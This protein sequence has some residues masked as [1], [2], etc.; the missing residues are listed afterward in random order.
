MQVS[1]PITVP[2]DAGHVACDH[3][4]RRTRIDFAS[5][6]G[7]ATSG[8]GNPAHLDRADPDDSDLRAGL[9]E[10]RARTCSR[11]IRSPMRP[12]TRFSS[13]RCSRTTATIKGKRSRCWRERIPYLGIA[14]AFYVPI[15]GAVLL[16]ISSNSGVFGSSRI[17]YAMSRSSLL[18]SIFQRVHAKFRT[19]A[20]SIVAFGGVAVLEL[21]LRRFRRSIRAR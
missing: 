20:I 3:L 2:A 4:V 1:W 13:G 8:L 12:A 9:F 16:L 14:G 11:R 5:R 21:S 19:P 17:A 18:P 15:L 7:D 6:P 10:S